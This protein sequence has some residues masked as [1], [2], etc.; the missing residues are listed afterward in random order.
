MVNM[1]MSVGGRVQFLV[2]KDDLERNAVEEANSTELDGVPTRV[3]S[4][5]HL[6]AIALRTGRA[7][8]HARLVQLLEERAVDRKKLQIII[9]RYGLSSQAE[10]FERRFGSNF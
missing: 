6:A 4:A 10:Q 1:S 8:D 5:E 7:K 3:M 2:P 9:E